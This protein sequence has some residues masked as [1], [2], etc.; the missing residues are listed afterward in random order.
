MTQL[1]ILLKESYL[2]IKYQHPPNPNPHTCR[3]F[4]LLSASVLL[5]S[6]WS[7]HRKQAA[8][9]FASSWIMSLN[10]LARTK[11]AFQLF[12][13]VSVCSLE[14]WDMWRV[15]FKFLD[16][17][18]LMEAPLLVPPA[19]LQLSDLG[20][21]SWRRCP[22]LTYAVLWSR[23]VPADMLN[24]SA[25]HPSCDS[26]SGTEFWSPLSLFYFLNLMP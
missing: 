11:A 4:V 2:D 25:V 1:Y 7:Q 17:F 22:C 23:N 14:R 10:Y 26:D 15:W 24:Y 8:D 16:C 12:S 20:P 19:A 21:L 5:Q 3:L 6:I 9:L 13:T 18:M